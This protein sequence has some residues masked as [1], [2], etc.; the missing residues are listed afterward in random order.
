MKSRQPIAILLFL[1]LALPQGHPRSHVTL[2]LMPP[3]H[4]V[5]R[6]NPN[7][8]LTVFNIMRSLQLTLPPGAVLV[9]DVGPRLSATGTLAGPEENIG[10]PHPVVVPGGVYPV[11]DLQDDAYAA[12]NHDYL[13]VLMD[14]FE[15]VLGHLGLSPAEARRDGYRANK[16]ARLMRVFTEIRMHQASGDE[17]R[18]SPAIGWCRVTLKEP[19]GNF[20]EDETH[21]FLLVATEEGWHVIN[22]WTRDIRR[23]QNNDQRWFLELVVL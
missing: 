10:E 15:T 16:V 22:P 1:L 21:T 4:L 19:W 5:E 6:M 14:W 20:A 8:T 23:L 9:Q 3:P 18:L 2:P 13:P 11:L 17:S 12:L 7:S